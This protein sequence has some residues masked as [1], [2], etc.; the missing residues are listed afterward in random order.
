MTFVLFPLCA[1]AYDRE[2]AGCYKSVKLEYT[3]IDENNAPITLSEMVTIP[4]EKD[5]ETVRTVKF[6]V[7]SSMPFT[8]KDK[9]GSTGEQPLDWGLLRTI[10]T[11]G[12]MVVQVD[13]EGFG[14]SSGRVSPFLINK[15]TARQSIDGLLAAIDY[16]NG[17]GIRISEDYY[18]LNTGYS[19]A[20]GLAVAVQRYLE[21]YCNEEVKEK[22]RLRRTIC[23]GAPIN[24]TESARLLITQNVRRTD[25]IPMTLIN[26]FLKVYAE[27]CLHTVTMSDL[28]DEWGYL[29]QDVVDASS[30]AGKAFWKALSLEDMDNDWVPE[31]PILDLHFANDELVSYGNVESALRNWGH[32][33]FRLFDPT[34]SKYRWNVS[35]LRPVAEALNRN[36]TESPHSLGAINYYIGMI[37]GCLRDTTIA[38]T[39]GKVMNF[40]DMLVTLFDITLGFNKDLRVNLSTTL[41]NG[42]LTI[43]TLRNMH[44]TADFVDEE[45]NTSTLSVTLKP[46]PVDSLASEG[47]KGIDARGYLHLPLEFDIILAKKVL[48]YDLPIHGTC[49]DLGQLLEQIS[50]I[51]LH[52]T[53]PDAETAEMY[54]N[55]INKNL[56]LE[57][58]IV[59]VDMQII[60]WYT[61]ESLFS[62]ECTIEPYVMHNGTKLPLDYFLILAGADVNVSDLLTLE[63]RELELGG[64]RII[65]HVTDRKYGEVDMYADILTPDSTGIGRIDMILTPANMNESGTLASLNIDFTVNL[66]G[67]HMKIEGQCSNINQLVLCAVLCSGNL[68]CQSEDEAKAYADAVNERIGMRLYVEKT[69]DD[70]KYADLGYVDYGCLHAVVAQDEFGAYFVQFCLNWMNQKDVPLQYIL[71]KIG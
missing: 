49:N 46:E 70:G 4:L 56:Y 63:N 23:G 64:K 51:A 66:W 16:A 50:A 52:R 32:D 53:C 55:E 39:Y 25:A 17:K 29:K 45:G 1:S 15:L 58:D 59:G 30:P 10:A 48:D 34:P 12:A 35:M 42:V 43:R 36:M 37:D 19:R 5:G 67:Y 13:G 44:F 14:S 60:A 57:A 33:K 8:T 20:G 40:N 54:C 41:Q 6:F 61:A 26:S 3:S 69:G 65:F 11:E 7:L 24:A 9:E 22:V 31:V 38:S 2:Y 28:F 21:L 71:N 47:I 27:G 18:T 62:D 68:S